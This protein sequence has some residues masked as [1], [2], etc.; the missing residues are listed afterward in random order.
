MSATSSS[1]RAHTVGDRIRLVGDADHP[2][3]ALRDHDLDGLHVGL[4]ERHAVEVDVEADAASR[5]LGEGGREA[6]RAEILQRL[7]EPALDER[8]ARLDQ[9]L[10]RERV[11]DL[12]GRALVLVVVGELLA[13][14]HARAADPVAPR[15]RAEED[16]VVA[17]SSG[18]GARHAVGREEPD[19]HRV[20]ERV[21]RVG[22]VEDRVAADGGD[23]DAVPVVA[24][25][26]DR[27]AELEPGLAE[28]Q[29]VEERDRAGAHG[30]DVAEDPADPRRRA[31]EGLDRGRMVVALDLERDGLA[32]AE[33][34]DA[35]VLARPLQDSRR[36][37]W[38]SA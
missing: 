5:H 17:G 18:L 30:D 23:A 32:L 19:A 12:D 4:A 8:E 3:L 16:D 26:A 13:R 15:G 11:A 22:V 34:D 25:A 24:D 2:L 10:A 27:A 37:P 21:R 20:D 35:R 14:E 1:Q 6:R 38:G 28:A 9:L 7:D 29:A 31:L 36:P 33:V